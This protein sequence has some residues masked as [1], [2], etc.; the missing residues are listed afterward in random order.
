MVLDAATP[1][2]ARDPCQ[3]PVIVSSRVSLLFHKVEG[4]CHEWKRVVEVGP[5]ALLQ[6]EKNIVDPEVAEHE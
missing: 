1:L 6:V 5:T 2:S 3:T 4:K